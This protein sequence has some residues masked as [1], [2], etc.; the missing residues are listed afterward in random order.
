[1]VGIAIDPHVSQ[2]L[3]D[4]YVARVGVKDSINEAMMARWVLLSSLCF[5]GTLTRTL[6]AIVSYHRAE[7]LSITEVFDSKIVGANYSRLLRPLIKR[8]KPSK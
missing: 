1:M 2:A 7:G 8:A 3:R 4:L 5:P 6:D